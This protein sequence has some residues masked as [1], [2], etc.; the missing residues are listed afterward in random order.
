[1]PR[2]LSVVIML[3]TALV[4]ATVAVASSP[5][6]RTGKSA[7]HTRTMRLTAS[8]FADRDFDVRPRGISLGDNFVAT[9]NLFRGGKKVGED[10]GTCEITR[11]EPKRGK[12]KTGGLQCLVTLVLPEGQITLQGARTAVLA[13][14]EPPRFVLAVTGG[15][16][17]FRNARGTVRIVDLNRT[18]SRLTVRLIG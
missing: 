6:N 3:A 4:V 2:S 11:L 13:S 17:A 15:T 8:S 18:D 10:H 1:M 16:G 12:A 5:D 14:Q 9:E 7:R